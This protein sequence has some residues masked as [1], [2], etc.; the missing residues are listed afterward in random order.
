MNDSRALPMIGSSILGVA[1]V[2]W[3]Q[4]L[5]VINVIGYFSWI[6]PA[7][8]TS[9]FY[10]FWNGFFL[11]S[12]SRSPCALCALLSMMKASALGSALSSDWNSWWNWVVIWLCCEAALRSFRCG[13]EAARSGDTDLGRPCYPSLLPCLALQRSHGGLV[14]WYLS[15]PMSRK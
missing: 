12:F 8:L 15:H 10:S 6:F 1:W 4:L 7:A 3:Q 14:F 11:C 13:E 2:Y 5:K 9:Y